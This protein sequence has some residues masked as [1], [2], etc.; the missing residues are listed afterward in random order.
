MIVMLVSSRWVWAPEL[1]STAITR[2]SGTLSPQR[3][4]Y[5]WAIRWLTAFEVTESR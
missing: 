5:S 2:H 3:L 4:R 1:P